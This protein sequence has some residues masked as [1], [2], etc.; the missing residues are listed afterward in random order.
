MDAMKIMLNNLKGLQ[1]GKYEKR[2]VCFIDILGYSE[3]LL[4]SAKP[5]DLALLISIM[6]L[7]KNSADEKSRLTAQYFSDCM[8]VTV[9]KM[10]IEE[11]FDFL[12][13]LYNQ[14]L[15]SSF[16]VMA[17]NHQN[18][19]EI[20]NNI[21]CDFLAM[22]RGGITYGDICIHDKNEQ[23]CSSYE[24][25]I[26]PMM[27]GPAIAT[28]H[29]LESKVAKYPRIVIDDLASAEIQ[30]KMSKEYVKKDFDGERYFDFLSYLAQNHELA[31][32]E[33]EMI[34]RTTKYLNE[35]RANVDYGVKEKY[36][37]MLN[38]LKP[39]LKS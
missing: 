14:L 5:S 23:D 21:M 13:K 32:G 2:F 6:D 30:E 18:E 9:E 27:V 36:G 17:E 31:D 12:A 37:W 19:A 15:C 26:S 8:Y 39:Y 22:L 20:C 1:E 34:I 28:A 35:N 38:Y 25:S 3:Q 33:K 16:I 10:Y 7:Y 29:I 24:M 11:L 4:K